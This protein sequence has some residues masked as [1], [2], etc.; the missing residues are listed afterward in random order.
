MRI[1]H[2]ELEHEFLGQA[3]YT[4]AVIT[5]PESALEPLRENE[6]CCVR[7]LEWRGTFSSQLTTTNTQL[8][9]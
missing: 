8:P 2:T 3:A 5:V 6:V 1:V 4:L 7:T 9:S